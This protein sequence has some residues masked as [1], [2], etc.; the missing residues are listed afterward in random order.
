MD[1]Y[2]LL[3]LSFQDTTAKILFSIMVFAASLISAK[4]AVFVLERYV[5][6]M[7][8]K[9]K[10]DVDD[11]IVFALKT[12]LYLSMLAAGS[13]ISLNMVAP[14]YS[15]AI[16]LFAKLFLIL[17]GFWFASR[18][19]S[20]LSVSALK[21]SGIKKDL[22]NEKTINNLSKI[23]KISVL[24]VGFMFMLGEAGIEITPLLASAG[25]LSLAVAL[26]AQETLSNLISG[27][28]L[29]VSKPFRIGDAVTIAGEYGYVEDMTLRHTVIRLW[30]NKR[31]ILPN[32]LLSKEKII[33]YSIGDPSMLAK[34][35]VGISYESDIGKAMEIMKE[36]AR[37]HKD[38]MADM[39]PS[40]A[41]LGFGDSSINLCLY[42]K[43]KDQP[44]AFA[45]SCDLRKSIKEEFD[46]NGIEIPYPRRHI[47]MQDKEA[48]RKSRF[49]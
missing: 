36:C 42:C 4:A 34:V 18:L 11:K 32:S 7:A 47:I 39:E 19:V 17:A 3:G 28:S 49:P 21:T 25:I 46:G 22:L 12:P 29:A 31:M 30:D 40:A 15:A 6:K 1:I 26:A 43:A 45:M 16:N 14:D 9:S 33:N 44:S 24:A 20:I 8:A 38:F 5:K 37:K 10:T 48:P 35:E 13:A 23:L 41:V 2:A 27:A